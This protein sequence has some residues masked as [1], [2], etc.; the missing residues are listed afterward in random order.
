MK[1]YNEIAKR[2]L[3]RRDKYEEAKKIK[4]QNIL[5]I[6][7][8][9]GCIVIV[10]AISFGILRVNWL[11][12]QFSDILTFYSE[13]TDVDEG[14]QT[15]PG[16]TTDKAHGSVP[17]TLPTAPTTIIQQS[18]T[19]T[20]AEPY[21]DWESKSMP[22]KFCTLG[23]NDMQSL[24]TIIDSNTYNG[25]KE[26]VY[27]FSPREEI[28]TTRNTS[29]LVTDIPIEA[30]APDGITHQTLVDIYSLEGLSDDLAVGVKFKDDDRIYTYVCSSYI[31]KTLGEFLDA[32]DYDNTVSYGGI[33]LYV[34]NL[35]PVN[36]KNRADIKSYLFSD[37]SVSNK[38]DADG[39]ASGYTVTAT[40][41][42]RE[43]GREGKIMRIHESGHIITNL[44]GY[45]YSFFV[46]KE[47]VENF[48]KESYNITFEEIAAIANTTQP[49]TSPTTTSPTTMPPTTTAPA[50]IYPAEAVDSDTNATSS[51]TEELVTASHTITT[52]QPNTAATNSWQ[53]TTDTQQIS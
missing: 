34:G 43:L 1:D 23:L 38:T 50:T 52:T 5:Q 16:N 48:L 26:Y 46:G 53:Y 40:V 2:V 37:G 20:N 12:A 45:E 6:S 9:F 19:T 28:A 41:N 29:L 25:S 3:S 31:P 39:E 42:C 27:P 49:L 22:G 7:G 44:I 18:Q 11:K 51:I 17:A 14:S 32:T 15:E 21:E 13:Y 36:D 47:A 4:K 8:A 24:N 35:F 30:T 10:T 33:M